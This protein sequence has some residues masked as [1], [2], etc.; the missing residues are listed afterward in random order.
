M[1]DRPGPSLVLAT[2]G[3]RARKVSVSASAVQTGPD[4]DRGSGQTRTS[5]SS[6][7]RVR[8]AGGRSGVAGRPGAVFLPRSLP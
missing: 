6:G 5:P 2:E 3:A 8:L 4:H 1:T 7:S